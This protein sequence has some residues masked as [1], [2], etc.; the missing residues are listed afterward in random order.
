MKSLII[1]FLLIVFALLSGVWFGAL[2]GGEQW[3]DLTF[4][5]IGDLLE[6]KEEVNQCPNF[7][8]L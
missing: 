1:T 4:S 7:T 5:C 6:C 2:I 8:N 3:K